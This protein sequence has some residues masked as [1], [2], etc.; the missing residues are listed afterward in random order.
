MRRREAIVIMLLVL[1]GIIVYVSMA[2]RPATWNHKITNPPE[3]LWRAKNVINES[4]C[5]GTV[6]GDVDGDDR[7][8]VVCSESEASSGVSRITVRDGPTGIVEWSM[9][10][11]TGFPT[12]MA[13]GD[14]NNDG[15]PEVVMGLDGIG[16]V[17]LF[18]NGTVMWTRTLAT[19]MRPNLAPSVTKLKSGNEPS[20]V[21]PTTNGT[22]YLLSGTDGE[23]VWSSIVGHTIERPAAVADLDGDG[24]REIVVTS[25]EN[26]TRYV[27]VLNSTDGSIVWR[28]VWDADEDSS[29][30][31]MPVIVDV[32]CDGTQEVIV[33]SQTTVVELNGDDGSKRWV[34]PRGGNHINPSVPP[35]V[36]DV[37]GDGQLD[38]VFTIDLM[39]VRAVNGL[40]GSLLW[41]FDVGSSF[42]FVNHVLVADLDDDRGM[43]VAIS[44]LTSGVMCLNGE[45]ASVQWV[46]MITDMEIYGQYAP[47]VGN[48][49]MDGRLD[50]VVPCFPDANIYVIS[51]KETGHVVCWQPRGGAS[52]FHNTFAVGDIDSDFDGLPDSL[53]VSLG[54]DQVNADTDNDGIPDSW[55]YRWGYNASSS[56][57][58]AEELIRYNA[59]S[60]VAGASLVLA[61][62]VAFVILRVKFHIDMRRWRR[63]TSHEQDV[64]AIPS[65]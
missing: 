30:L 54:T 42:G 1:S 19:E 16:V 25:E 23:I 38:I 58:P 52:D 47:A 18:G 26:W 44:T 56:V 5:Y 43:E 27:S 8:E 35:A 39:Y 65:A 53:E 12:D 33:T 62:A 7:Q 17:A 24:R 13:L 63:P 4:F 20:V 60:I 61:I 46:H 32:D 55:E 50:L 40:D 45:D 29:T 31:S 21:L 2:G 37:N 48:V 49:D 51:P 22:V 10:F 6:I 64:S 57:V 28:A 11:T 41:T 36:A 15:A 59:I 14:L 3:Y 9:G 34:I